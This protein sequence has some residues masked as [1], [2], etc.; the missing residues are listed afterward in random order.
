MAAARHYGGMK[1]LCL[2]LFLAAADEETAI[3]KAIATF[4]HMSERASVLTRKAQVPDFSRCWQQERSQ[5]YFEPGA[6][7]F[8]TDGVALADATG[9]RYGGMVAKE[10]WPALFVLKKEG[11]DWKIDAL[12]VFESCLAIVPL[13]Q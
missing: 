1:T 10:T 7:R 11:A 8:V 6:I 4:N 3:R 2:L 13:K 12:R 5:M 9:S